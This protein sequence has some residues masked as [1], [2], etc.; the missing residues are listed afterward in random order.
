[1]PRFH[2]EARDPA[3]GTVTGDIDA[4]NR[5]HAFVL[6]RERGLAVDALVDAARAARSRAASWGQGPFYP[7]WPMRPSSVALFFDQLG[8]LLSAGVTPHEAFSALQD[9]VGGRLRRVAREGAETFARGGS[10]SSH[11]ERYP[12]F[13]PPHLVAIFRAG[14]RSGQYADACREIV[15]QCDIETKTRR[16]VTLLKVYLVIMLAPCILI[17]SFPRIISKVIAANPNQMTVPQ[18][19][20]QI[21]EY[22]RPG[23]QAYGHH[24]LF[25]ILPWVLL[26]YVL[27]KVLAVVL[28]L[29]AMAGLRDWLTLYTPLLSMHTRR[30]A[31]ARFARV[32]ELMLHAGAPLGDAVREAAR[33]TGNRLVAQRVTEPA[34]RL[35]RGGRLSE[36]LHASGIFSPSQV[37]QIVTAEE[38][39]TLADGLGLIAENA[40]KSREQFLK[41]AGLGGCFT[42]FAIAAVFTLIAAIV[43]WTAVYE[44]IFR[45]F[46]G[47]SWQP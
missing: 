32:L 7:L 33:A 19:F 6:L 17:P 2:Y 15:A 29:P 20:D 18:G 11:L 1:M 35:D 40:R 12:R 43:G 47:P 21:Y 3:G 34:E 44:E 14:E 36:A 39:G 16:F 9:R 38:S 5:G 41:G 31:V 30:A 26:A 23:L 4:T 24:V 8:R 22:L 28:H 46:E 13:F 10:V 25:G 42:A 27:A 37:S 45:V